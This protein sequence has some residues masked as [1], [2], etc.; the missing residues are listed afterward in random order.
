MTKTLSKV[1]AIILA[2]SMLF[3]VPVMAGTEEAA[4]FAVSGSLAS[5]TGNWDTDYAEMIVIKIKGGAKSIGEGAAVTIGFGDSLSNIKTVNVSS[6]DCVF[7]S[8]GDVLVYVPFINYVDHAATYNFYFAEGTFV[9]E[10]GATSEEL[11][12]NITGNEIIETLDVEHISVKPIEKL[13]DWMYTWGAEG[14]WLDVINF[15]V[16]ILNWFLTI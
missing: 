10:D 3:A 12:V 9:S 5:V 14:F 13:I 8:N 2:L 11:T 4:T 6:A 1:M 15:V 16:S 7:E